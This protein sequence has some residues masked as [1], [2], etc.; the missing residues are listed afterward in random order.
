MLMILPQL[1]KLYRQDHELSLR[2][3]ARLIGM[4]HSA[5]HRFE[6]GRSLD[7]KQFARLLTW[8]LNGPGKR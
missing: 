3:A 7:Q 6:G 8:V 2:Q 5:L 1:L 4:D